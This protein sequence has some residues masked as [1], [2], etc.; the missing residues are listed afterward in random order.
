MRNPWA[1]EYAKTP[2]RYIWGK[3][4]SR[5]ARELTAFVPPGGRILDLGCGEGRDS[6]YFAFCGYEVTG[7]DISEAGLE[8]AKTRG[9][10]LNAHVVFTDLRVYVEKDEEIDYFSAGE[11]AEAY[12]GWLVIR[13]EDGLVPCA[14][15]GVQHLH[16]VE[17]LVTTP[18]AQR[19]PGLR[20][21]IPPILL[22][23]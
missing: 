21:A 2:D 7:L 6:V 23:A 3:A 12:A 4:P 5:F 9:R 15:D 1:R 19:V 11:L 16:S 13:H 18:V 20:R 14:Q 22:T 17:R 10:G 8:K